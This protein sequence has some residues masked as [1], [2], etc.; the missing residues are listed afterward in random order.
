MLS[1]GKFA[2]AGGVGVETVRYYQRKG[3]LETPKP[4]GGIRRYAEEDLRRLR[5]I[6][7]AQAAGFTLQE[8]KELIKL[9]VS[10]DRPKVRALASA[11]IDALNIKIKELEKARNAL[12]KLARECAHGDS[13]PCPILE[14]FEG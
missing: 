2:A 3:L 12:K 11:R 5:F 10:Q 8:I 13:G 9:E 6:R 1:I 7:K 4:S 14:A